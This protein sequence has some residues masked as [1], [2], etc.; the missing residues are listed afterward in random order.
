MG[1]VVEER[2]VEADRAVVVGETIEGDA[3]GAP[4]HQAA[5]GRIEGELGAVHQDVGHGFRVPLSFKEA[6]QALDGPFREGRRA[7]ASSLRLRGSFA[8]PAI[9]RELE[10]VA[11]DR[12]GE[13]RVRHRAARDLR[14]FTQQ[15]EVAPRGLRQPQQRLHERPAGAAP[16]QVRESRKELG[17]GRVLVERE[18]QRLF[19]GVV[20]AA[21]IAVPCREAGLQVARGVPAE[22]LRGEGPTE[23]ARGHVPGRRTLGLVLESGDDLPRRRLPC[24]GQVDDRARRHVPLAQPCGDTHRGARGGHVRGLRDDLEIGREGAARIAEAHLEHDA[25]LLPEPRHERQVPARGSV[26]RLAVGVDECLRRARGVGEARDLAGDLLVARRDRERL[27]HGLECQRRVA[28]AL[29][30]DLRGLEE[31]GELLALRARGQ[32]PV[33]REL[34]NRAPVVACAQRVEQ[35]ADRGGA[36]LVLVREC[37]QSSAG[38]GVASVGLERQGVRPHARFL[39]VEPPALDVSE[40]AQELRPRHAVHRPVRAP[41]IQGGEFLPSLG[42]P[43]ESREGDCR[44]LRFSEVL[45]DAPPRDDRVLRSIEHLAEELRHAHSIGPPPVDVRRGRGS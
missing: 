31:D 45:L 1:I 18:A 24:A 5:N 22:L 7:L 39:R 34:E 33:G 2:K 17:V 37:P 38:A 11:E 16:L 19:R 15:S 36:V 21:P 12:A 26:D 20:I 42:L 8:D 6:R 27:P 44:V 43:Q 29:L 32:Q 23:R 41:G 35:H 3:R 9:A 13:R 10:D 28:R 4:S 25:H 14:R 30:G 40:L